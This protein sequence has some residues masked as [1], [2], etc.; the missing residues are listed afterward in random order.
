MGFFAVSGYLIT[1]SAQRSSTLKGYALARLTRIYP[2]LLV[3]ALIVG[4]VA[5]PIVALITHGRYDIGG[6][7]LF[8]E[9]A[10]A[11]LIGLIGPPLIGTSLLG[12][13]DSGDWNGPL[14][15]LTW[16]MLCYVIVALVVFGLGSLRQ[17]QHSG[18]VTIVLFTAATGALA[19][20]TWN[21]GFG[22]DPREFALPLAATF[23]AGSVLAHHRDVVSTR[24]VPLL[25]AASATWAA[26]AS[27]LTNVLAPLP[28]AYLILRLGSLRSFSRIGS[29][30]DISYGV[31]IY[32]WP[33]QQL[34]A[35]LHLP[36]VLPPLGYAAIA[37]VAVW[38]FAFL[39]CVLVEQPAQR[40][41]RSWGQ[42]R[43]ILA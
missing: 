38:P 19:L 15:T 14:W 34:L 31:Y 13:A 35:A 1:L 9:F 24:A 7:L 8:V 10:L 27:G 3:S 42:R 5:A 33:I 41:R 16:E 17:G 28:F 4:F 22:Q 25:F 40:M 12:N 26:L 6:A 21:G 39:S 11:L 37:L 30:F 29:R 20:K 32:G 18:A 36:T 43:S 2:A 23:L